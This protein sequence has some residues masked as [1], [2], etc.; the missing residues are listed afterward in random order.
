MFGARSENGEPSADRRHN[1][2]IF[3]QIRHGYFT[4]KYTKTVK[5]GNKPNNNTLQ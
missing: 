4:L 2:F 3:Q 1:T 5:N